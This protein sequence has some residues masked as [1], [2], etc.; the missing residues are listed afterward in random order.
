MKTINELVTYKTKCIDRRD[1][2]RLMDFVPEK[3]I[4]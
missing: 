3:Q 2:Y 1:L 4:A